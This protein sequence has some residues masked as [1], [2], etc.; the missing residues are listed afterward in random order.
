MR[1]GSSFDE[2]QTPPYRRQLLRLNAEAAVK[3][4]RL[5][6]LS[7]LDEEPTVPL[8]TEVEEKAFELLVQLLIAIIP[9]LDGER[10]DEQDQQ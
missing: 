3:Q 6:Q 9:T 1:R 7:L 10:R 2:S 8:P 4:T 5:R